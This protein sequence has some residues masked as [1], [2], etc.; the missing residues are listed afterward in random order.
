MDGCARLVGTPGGSTQTMAA[1]VTADTVRQ[2][3]VEITVGL[4][5]LGPRSPLFLV[6]HSF[7]KKFTQTLTHTDTHTHTLSW[8]RTKTLHRAFPL[9][10]WTWRLTQELAI[11]KAGL[12]F[13]HLTLVV[14]SIVKVINMEEEDQPVM[15]PL[16]AISP[17][18]WANTCFNKQLTVLMKATSH[19]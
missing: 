2:V 3:G 19:C 14:R 4:A 7:W 5:P 15:F 16:C 13:I 8:P 12:T 6:A 17:K 10:C 18:S 11:E 1:W 9:T